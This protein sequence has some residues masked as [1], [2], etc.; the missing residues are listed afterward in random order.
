MVAAAMSGAKKG[1]ALEVKSPDPKSSNLSSWGTSSEDSSR[2]CV[3]KSDKENAPD[4]RSDV[5]TARLATPRKE[6]TKTDGKK[7]DE[8]SWA[9]LSAF[10]DPSTRRSIYKRDADLVKT[11]QVKCE[12]VKQAIETDTERT[13]RTDLRDP[14]DMEINSLYQDYKNKKKYSFIVPNN[15]YFGDRDKAKPVVPSSEIVQ[16]APSL[17]S[18]IVAAFWGF[19]GYK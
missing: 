10:K 16:D 6:K 8:D 19:L 17:W 3:Y 15:V 14:S 9:S 13:D 11:A 4:Y 12:E 18:I 7:K 2:E 1:P 5:K